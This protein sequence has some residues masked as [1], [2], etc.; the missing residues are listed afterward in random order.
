[1]RQR[2]GGLI[3]AIVMLGFGGH[4]TYAPAEYERV[5][6]R[7]T[8]R[9]ALEGQAF[10]YVTERVGARPIGII[11]VG[12]GAFVSYLALKPRKDRGK[13]GY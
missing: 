7:T 1:L 12:A 5:P 2:I 4:M 8:G 3:F 10:A 9:R 6:I 13:R 11:F